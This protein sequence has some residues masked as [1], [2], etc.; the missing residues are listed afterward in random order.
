MVNDEPEAVLALGGAMTTN[1]YL[2]AKLAAKNTWQVSLSEFILAMS[3]LSDGATLKELWLD[4]PSL[5]M[6]LGALGE[7]RI[8]E[9]KEQCEREWQQGLYFT[10]P[11]HEFYP[12][13]FLHV[14]QPPFFIQ[15]KGNPLWTLTGGL[16]IVGTRD[17]SLSSLE[18]IE[19]QMREF[20]KRN[21]PYTVSGGARGVDSHVHRMSLWHRIPTVVVVPSGL[22]SLYP[23]NLESL[24]TELLKAGGAILSEYESSQEMKK[25][26]FQ[27]RNRLIAALG[28]CTLVVEAAPKSGTFLTARLTLEQGKPVLVMPTHPMETRGRGGL[29]LLCDGAIPVRDAA[30]VCMH[31][32][33]EQK[34]A[35]PIPS[36]EVWGLPLEAAAKSN[37]L[38]V[39]SLFEKSEKI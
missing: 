22:L 10:F 19:M 4:F 29:D 15:Y 12:T 21:I 39:M 1:H 36:G 35:Q 13:S 24:Q 6:L 5:W 2:L 26:H 14:D 28:L 18:W 17:P 23:K 20:Q 8:S 9:F 11:G 16:S 27:A 33:A 31:Y 37:S 7:K 34:W 30:D 3:R 32:F 38:E 25:H